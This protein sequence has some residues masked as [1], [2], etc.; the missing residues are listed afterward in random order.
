MA[1]TI[2]EFDGFKLN[3]ARTFQNEL[4]NS[5]KT[6][7]EV[8]QAMAAQYKLE[9]DKLKIFLDAIAVSESKFQHL[10]RIV[11]Y[12]PEEGKTNPPGSMDKDGKAY[13]AEYFFVPQAKKERPSFKKGRG[14]RFSKKGKGGGRHSR[15]EKG[16]SA[17]P[18]NAENNDAPGAGERGERKRRPFKPRRPSTQK[19]I[20]SQGLPKPLPVP[21]SSASESTVTSTSA[22]VEGSSDTS[23]STQ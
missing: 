12:Q 18:S 7:E 8:A 15:N 10:K 17:S 1:K 11:V 22:K 6:E 13:L 19:P 14:K 21:S 4:K 2:T 3:L 23:S 20:S 9:G 5:G 16:V